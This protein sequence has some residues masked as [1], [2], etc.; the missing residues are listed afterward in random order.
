MS[1]PAVFYA[2]LSLP[3]FL[4]LFFGLDVSNR[5][6]S[7]WLKTTCQVCQ[8]PIRKGKAMP[9]KRPLSFLLAAVTGFVVVTARSTARGGQDAV[10][11]ADSS[12]SRHGARIDASGS[13]HFIVYAPEAEGVELLLF[14]SDD[15]RT[16]SRSFPMHKHGDDWKVRLSGQGVGAGMRYMYRAKGP[17]RVSKTDVYEP[18]F[19]EQYVLNDPYAFQTRNV[20]YSTFFDGKPDVHA[21][22]QVY[23]GGAK[24]VV[25]DHSLD[26]NPGHVDRKPQDLIV[27]ELHVQDYTSRIPGIDPRK[28]GK[29]PGLV[30]P[31]LKTPGGL[32]AGIDH[33]VELG[34]TAVELMPVMEYDE[35]TG[36][37]PGRL[38]H[39]GYMTTNFFAPETR[40][41]SDP[42]HDV[43]EL[44]Q[45]VKAF[46]DRGIA[47]FLD[48]V[49]NHTGEQG[50]W[51]EDGRV[52]AKYYNFMGL[53]NTRVYRP[54][55]DGRFYQNDT[56]T[57][58]D[59]DFS[60][61]AGRFTKKLT[62]DSL[63]LWYNAYGID[64]F[65]FDLARVLAV[66]SD[67]AAE[68][69]DNAR[70]FAPASLHAEPWDMG[71]A[72]FDF[73][74]NYGYNANNNRWAKWV[75]KFRD[76]IRNFSKSTLTSRSAFKR[77]LEGYGSNGGKG[78]A[79]SRPWHRSIS[80]PSTMAT[81]SATPSSLTTTAARTTAGTAGATRTSGASARSS[82]WACFSPRKVS[83]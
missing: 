63:S 71:G 6:Q 39:W 14:G 56:G 66:D 7:I 60:G 81:P 55:S 59:V 29:Y 83:P 31:G 24:S 65:R 40:Y 80:S 25:Y 79:S 76:E 52:M 53:C 2:E 62:T 46:H 18:M 51:T 42:A 15:S 10:V 5:V 30:E 72:W 26:L 47:V 57:G 50:P 34:V 44:K 17:N 13:V 16:P 11:A 49:F 23:A 54:T 3:D 43:V 67:N 36:N 37:V 73:M 4:G 8:G 68:W 75:G 82:C 77:H 28:R 22:R 19:N 61:P 35:E 41:A 70:E 78:P 27:Y 12:E 33:L 32:S 58:N 20:S 38:N 9:A 74:D 45:V 21:D 69:V 1:D 64:G 48:V